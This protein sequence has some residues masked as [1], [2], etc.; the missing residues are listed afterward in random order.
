MMKQTI[1]KDKGFDIALIVINTHEEIVN[2][3][4]DYKI[5]QRFLNFGTNIKVW[6]D[7]ADKISYEEVSKNDSEFLKSLSIARKY[8]LETKI[9]IK[10]LYETKYLDNELNKKLTK[11]VDYILELLAEII[12]KGR[13]E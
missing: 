9:I 8:T 10:N 12:D 6:I 3:G 1:L 11:L 4:L 7:D 2:K 13:Y 5:A